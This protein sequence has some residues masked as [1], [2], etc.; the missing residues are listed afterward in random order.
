LLKDAPV[1]EDYL[2]LPQAPEGEEVV[3]DY[4]ALRLTLRS[5]PLALLR[6]EFLAVTLGGAEKSRKSSDGKNIAEICALT[7]EES[8]QF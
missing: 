5:H 4:S 3:F 7:V 8:L 6:P 1:H 2:E